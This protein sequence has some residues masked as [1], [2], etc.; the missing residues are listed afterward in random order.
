MSKIISNTTDVILKIL[1]HQNISPA[2]LVLDRDR[3]LSNPKAFIIHV[4]QEL[5]TKW[6]ID[7]NR[8]DD[9]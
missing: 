1:F 6:H 3:L 9:T 2:L 5:A 8:E 7:I 4:V